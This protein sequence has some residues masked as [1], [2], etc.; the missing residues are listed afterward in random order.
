MRIFLH[1][2][3][4]VLYKRQSFLKDSWGS[5]LS[6]STKHFFLYFISIHQLISP[7]SFSFALSFHSYF[8]FLLHPSHCSP[9]VPNLSS[10]SIHFTPSLLFYLFVYHIFPPFYLRMYLFFPRSAYSPSP[11]TLSPYY[12]LWPTTLLF[13]PI[14]PSFFVPLPSLPLPIYSP[15]PLLI[16][17]H[18]RFFYLFIPLPFSYLFFALL[19]LYLPSISLSI[20]PTSSLV[21]SL[22]SLILYA[23]HLPLHLSTFPLPIYSPSPRPSSFPTLLLLYSYLMCLPSFIFQSTKGYYKFSV[24]SGKT[25]TKR[26]I[27]A[28][29]EEVL[30][31]FCFPFLAFCTTPSPYSLNTTGATFLVLG[32]LKLVPS[33]S[34][35]NVTNFVIQMRLFSPCFD[36]DFAVCLAS[37]FDPPYCFMTSWEPWLAR[38]YSEL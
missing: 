1:Q 37:I 16:S 14:L 26:S 36:Q 6:L 8:Q 25:I 15:P 27:L 19:F 32:G 12:L 10:L 11:S 38:L 20:H 3:Y 31:T 17:L 23:H 9:P 24:S 33:I 5:Q 30:F 28:V 2:P 18:P 29:P 21:T 35:M 22:P 34:G 7:P 4:F 13:I